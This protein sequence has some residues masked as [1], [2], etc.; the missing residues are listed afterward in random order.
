MENKMSLSLDDKEGLIKHLK[1]NTFI[2]V[3]TGCWEWLGAI[4][5]QYGR[6]EIDAIQYSVHRVSLYIYK[7][8][9]LDGELKALHTLNC[10]FKHCWNP[11]H[12][13]AG[14]DVENQQDVL[15]V[16]NNFYKKKT[17]CPRGHEYN[18]KNTYIHKNSGHRVCRLC[19]NLIQNKKYSENKA[20]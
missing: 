8:F 20:R 10:P 13:Y 6:F 5:N 7:K 1:E 15:K 3:T 2:N 17:H 14:T 18:K 12:L 19:R 4:V 16:G 9:N 11:A